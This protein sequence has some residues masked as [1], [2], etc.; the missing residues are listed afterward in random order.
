MI[1]TSHLIFSNVSNLLAGLL[2]SDT[3]FY[4]LRISSVTPETDT[5]VCISFDVPAELK[6]TFS[7]TQG[8]FLT[9]SAIIDGKEI[10]RAYSICSGVDDDTLK[11][12]IKRVDGGVFSNYA[13]DNFK[14]GVE[15]NVLQPQGTFFTELNSENQKRYMC[16]AVGSGVT[17]ILS[18]TKSI[19]SR[20][21]KSFV[22]LLYGNRQTTQMMF[23][24]ELSFLKN[25]YLERLQLIHIMSMEDQG[26][27]LLS[28]RI[29][30]KKGYKLQKAGLI[31]IKNTDDVFI[32]GPESMMSEVSH[33]FR[34]E[35]LAEDR[36]HYE[37][38][39]SSAADAQKVLEKAK[40][41]REKFGDDKASKISLRADGRMITFPLSTVGENILD[42]GM[43]NGMELPYS[44]KAGV[45]STCKAKLVKG[46]VDMD[47]SHGLEP[48]EVEAGYI[49]TCQSHPTS[50]DVEVDF[51]KR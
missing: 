49:L 40:E 20:E 3:R 25:R 1:A 45:C 9:L 48:H 46:T 6:D 14:L 34:S 22:T 27:D 31:D 39:G 18:I 47:I 30:N 13:N 29:D 44:C 23:K 17:P 35:G 36:I 51:D 15:V 50:D 21:P 8:Q 33:G 26:T 4:P 24:E 5:A 10:R 43:R 7:F 2:M 42:A 28:G 11:V 16:L 41:R 38:F 19:L 32:C 12:G 37:L